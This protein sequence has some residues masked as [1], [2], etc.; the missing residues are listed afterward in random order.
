MDSK[1]PRSPEASSP[2]PRIIDANA[3][4]A[5]LRTE[6]AAARDLVN[7][8]RSLTE[9]MRAGARPGELEPLVS[10]YADTLDIVK[11]AAKAR[12]SYVNGPGGLARW[13][14][15]NRPSNAKELSALA[16]QARLL[17]EQI[18]RETE[19][20]AYLAQRVAG[21]YEAQRAWIV[22]LVTREIEPTGYGSHS[23]SGLASA[24]DRSA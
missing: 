7:A 2:A 24:V 11:A 20:A 23:R 19:Q 12:A 6:L 9:A 17:R 14:A 10:R 3:L 8:G 16:D 5:A 13:I 15:T 21:W 22:E 18:R 1:H 4:A